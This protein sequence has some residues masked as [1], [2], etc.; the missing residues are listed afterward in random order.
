LI[1]DDEPDAL[2]LFGRMLA[3][4]GRGYRVLL[5]R[6]GREAMG[7]LEQY[8][9]DAILLDL[10]MPNMDGFQLLE[11][12]KGDPALRDIPV[13]VISA[14]DPAGQPIVSSAL[15]VTR[16]GGLSVRQLLA[17]IEAVGEILSTTG[18]LAV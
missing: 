15:A 8:R 10:V 2:Q 3:L 14:R 17:S 1:V 6:D 18:K 12:R 16:G 5:A 13:V 7:I 4:P 11:A 9:P